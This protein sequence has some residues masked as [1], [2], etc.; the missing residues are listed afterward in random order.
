[1]L[2]RFKNVLAIVS[3]A[4]NSHPE[5]KL[6]IFWK[7]PPPTPTRRDYYLHIAQRLVEIIV[8]CISQK[9]KVNNFYV[10]V[11][12]YFSNLPSTPFICIR[13]SNMM[14]YFFLPLQRK[15]EELLFSNKCFRKSIMWYLRVT[16]QFSPHPSLTIKNSQSFVDFSSEKHT[17]SQVCRHSDDRCTS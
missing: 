12:H 15:K 5:L 10:P 13:S 16:N 8:I 7:T 3:A 9:F 1:M 4:F 6:N 17:I 11:V 14:R 2:W